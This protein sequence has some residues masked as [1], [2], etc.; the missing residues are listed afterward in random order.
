MAL[1]FIPARHF[2]HGARAVEYDPIKYCL[3]PEPS[4]PSI[5]KLH[6]TCVV[7][8]LAEAQKT[9]PAFVDGEGPAKLNLEN[10]CGAA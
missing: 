5:L 3:S 1:D 4:Q 2:D 9:I 7:C 8:C 6:P 10:R